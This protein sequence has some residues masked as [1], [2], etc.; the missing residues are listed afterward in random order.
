MQLTFPPNPVIG[1]R[2]SYVDDLTVNTF[3]WDGSNWGQIVKKREVS[4]NWL[5]KMLFTETPAPTSVETVVQINPFETRVIHQQNFIRSMN[6]KVDLSSYK[7]TEYIGQSFM[8]FINVTDTIQ[9]TKFAVVGNTIKTEVDA[10]RVGDYLIFTIKN[11]YTNLI[12][13]TT[14]VVA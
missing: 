9:W 13:V 12:T 10:Q 6:L 3:I 1:D 7:G 5:G 2:F 14:S 11:L 8:L 4:I